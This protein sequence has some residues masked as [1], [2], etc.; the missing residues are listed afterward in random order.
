MYQQS[1]LKTLIPVRFGRLASLLLLVFTLDS[2]AFTEL[3]HAKGKKKA[4]PQSIDD[5]F[6]GPVEAPKSTPS[7]TTEPPAK[8]HPPEDEPRSIDALFGG[9]VE[10]PTSTPSQTTE[11]SSKPHPPEDEPRS[12]D[13]LFGEP[14]PPMQ[15]QEDISTSPS[16]LMPATAEEKDAGSIDA[17]FGAQPSALPPPATS[18][19]ATP[20]IL[21]NPLATSQARPP[22]PQARITGF[23]QNDLAY[24]YKSPTHWTKFRNTLELASTGQLSGGNAWKLGGRL[25]YD[26]IYDM[27]DHYSRSVRN[28]QRLEAQ[29]REAYIDIPANDWEFRLGRQ[30]IIWGE[31]AGLFFADVVSAKDLREL[32]LPDFE[33][34]RI[35]QWAARAEYFKGD[36]HAEGVWIPHMTYDDIG[37]PGAEFYPFRPPAGVSIAPEDKPTGL[38]NSAY[39]TRLSYLKSGW[40]VSGFYYSTNDPTAAFTRLA[41]TLYQP[42]HD[43]IHQLGATLGKDLG[44][45]VFKA[46]AVYT[47]D[48]L[49]NVTT[50]TD[51]DGLVKQNLLDYIVGLEWSFPQETRFNVQYY[52]RR[53]PDPE[54]G[55]LLDSTESGFTFLISTQALHQNIEPRLLFLRSINRNDW[56]AQFKVTWRLD[57]NWRLAAGADVFGGNAAGLFGQFGNK[58]RIYTEIRYNF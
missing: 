1:N 51:A 53:F 26:P 9:P 45:L 55:M 10:A 28:D 20:Q 39:G 21:E 29:I 4:D 57:G 50:P 22:S 30:H 48:K 14:A 36:F 52:Q 23:F 13:A 58:D 24:A 43:R 3:A 34:L 56:L 35:P 54:P 42:I 6:G 31:M 11:S 8:L 40:D 46:E 7:R 17:L 44:P 2:I 27:T 49:F 16:T 19:E 47:K 15:V 32:A 12:I 33:I 25:M 37:K 5:L 18:V 38:A 41:P